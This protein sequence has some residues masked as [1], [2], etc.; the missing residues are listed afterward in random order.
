M[1]R[2]G[3]AATSAGGSGIETPPTTQY[4]GPASRTPASTKAAPVKKTQRRDVAFRIASAKPSSTIS[5][6]TS[7]N[8]CSAPALASVHTRSASQST[9][10]Q[11][12]LWPPPT[13]QPTKLRTRN[14][15][16]PFA[17]SSCSDSRCVIFQ[18]L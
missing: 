3:L 4:A 18:R 11:D 10:R 17:R 8:G 1:K 6:T 16:S 14:R 5:G 15:R 7:R 2:A 12:W 9:G 13:A